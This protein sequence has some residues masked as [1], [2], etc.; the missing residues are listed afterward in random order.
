MGKFVGHH[1]LSIALLFFCCT[2][3][4]A[5]KNTEC[6]PNEFNNAF[7]KIELG[8]VAAVSLFFRNLPEKYFQNTQNFSNKPGRNYGFTQFYDFD[9][10]SLLDSGASIALQVNENFPN[11]RKDKK[12]A[13]LK[14]ITR[15]EINRK[16]EVRDYNRRT[17]AI[18]RHELF[19]QIRRKDRN[20]LIETLKGIDN[21]PALLIKQKLTVQHDDIVYLTTHFGKKYGAVTLSSIQVENF[22]VPNTHTILKIELF[23]KNNNQLSAEGEKRIARYL[24]CHKTRIRKRI[25]AYT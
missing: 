22:G 23:Q 21:Q 14:S 18:D 17:N 2:V 15:P 1:L 16:F 9:S 6:T 7:Y 19:R 12:S 3:N 24:L 25:P 11:Y 4:A 13:H 5:G 20:S 8:D 10:L